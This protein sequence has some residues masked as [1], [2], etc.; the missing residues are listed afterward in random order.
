MP[1]PPG[2]LTEKIKVPHPRPVPRARRPPH[3]MG[4]SRAAALPLMH[5]VLPH[6]T[7][8]PCPLTR[9]APP[10]VP[11]RVLTLKVKLR[12]GAVVLAQAL[13][14]GLALR[15]RRP[16]HGDEREGLLSN[17]CDTVT[18]SDWY[19]CGCEKPKG[20]ACVFATGAQGNG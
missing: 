13:Q 4:T 5:A 2:M 1:M 11:R 20:S 10:H 19:C 18:H 3:G 9:G 6:A 7:C 16:C 8:Q 17:G 15:A 12:Q 14:D